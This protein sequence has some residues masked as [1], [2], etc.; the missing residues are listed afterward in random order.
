VSYIIY[1]IHFCI[2]IATRKKVPS[3]IPYKQERE[4]NKKRKKIA[5]NK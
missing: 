5:N 3:C 1:S 2:I 4:K